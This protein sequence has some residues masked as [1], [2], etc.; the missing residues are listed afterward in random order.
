MKTF[1]LGKEGVAKRQ[2]VVCQAFPT[3]QDNP[4]RLR[5]R[6]KSSQDFTVAFFPLF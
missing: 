3:Y 1:L 5:D 6:V 4:R 2:G